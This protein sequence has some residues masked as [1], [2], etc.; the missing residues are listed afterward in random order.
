MNTADLVKEGWEYCTQGEDWVKEFSS[1]NA[2][3][4]LSLAPWDET[5]W[6]L[7]ITQFGKDRGVCLPFETLEQAVTA[8]N[9]IAAGR[10]VK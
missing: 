4:M 3:Y 10:G 5:R 9:A 8:A 2:R 1:G 6:T 7:T